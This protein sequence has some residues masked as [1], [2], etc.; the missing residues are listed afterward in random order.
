MI[1][2]MAVMAWRMREL[3]IAQMEMEFVTESMGVTF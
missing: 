1:A 2:G 3:R